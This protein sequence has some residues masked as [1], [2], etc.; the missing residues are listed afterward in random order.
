MKTLSKQHAIKQKNIL[1]ATVKL[2]DFKGN[3]TIKM[4]KIKNKD[5]SIK[6]TVIPTFKK[7]VTLN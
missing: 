3:L 7:V 5:V 2:I 6:P 4:M 1:S